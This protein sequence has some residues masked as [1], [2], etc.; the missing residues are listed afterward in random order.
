MAR[1]VPLK[2][3]IVGLGGI[4]NNHADCYT[5]NES[6]GV[7]AVC[8]IQQDRADAAAERLNCPAF[9]SIADMLASDVTLDAC[10][11]CTA[12][13][14]NG[15]DHY[16]A[17][18][19]L[20]AA[21][22]PVLGEKPISNNLDHAREMVALARE[23]N[24][25]YAINLNHRFTPAAE[26]AKGWCEEGRLGKLHMIKMRMWINNPN[27][28]SPWFHLRAL[29]PHS[30]DVMRYFAGDVKSV[31]CF[32]MKGEN[33]EIWSNAVI[34]LQFE[35]GMIGHL[36]GSYD[37]G[38][39]YGLEQCEVVG[40]KGRFVLD[41]ACEVLTYYDR[42]SPSTETFVNL[43]GMTT[44]GQT[45][46]SR[47]NAWVD[48]L[49][50]EVAPEDVDGSGSAGLAAQQIIEAAITSFETHAVVDL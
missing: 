10:S 1:E 28:S 7:V 48:Q 3:G 42:N 6:A 26:R 20:L 17:T 32:C 33:R 12:G 39:T 25:P 21:G 34:N 9:Y 35:N 36:T 29:H 37:A 8:D 22:L 15:G 16:Q 2:I 41:E 14:E 4:G 30:F 46:Q 23:K 31:Q 47:I 27:E 49:V 11:M 18:M 45:F 13:T 38:G 40:S 50:N 43:G 5:N 44:F 24:V 19:E